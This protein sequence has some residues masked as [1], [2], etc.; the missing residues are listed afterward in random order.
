MFGV[1]LAAGRTDACDGVLTGSMDGC[2]DGGKSAADGCGGLGAARMA[3]QA[4]SRA[5]ASWAGTKRDGE[6]YFFIPYGR[7]IVSSIASSKMFQPVHI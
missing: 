5:V 2:D 6:R 7:S 4:T 1:P 3:R